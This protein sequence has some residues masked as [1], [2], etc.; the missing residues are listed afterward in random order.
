[1]CIIYSVGLKM[2]DPSLGISIDYFQSSLTRILNRGFFLSQKLKMAFQ[3]PMNWKV[4]HEKS[5]TSGKT[6]VVSY[7]S[8][9][10]R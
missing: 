5:V 3:H 1:M 10:H 4:C 8:M 7:S 6:L 2:E 9:K